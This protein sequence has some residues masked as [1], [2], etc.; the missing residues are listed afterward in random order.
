MTAILITLLLA[1]ILGISIAWSKGFLTNSRTSTFLT[2]AVHAPLGFLNALRCSNRL[3]LANVAEGQSLNGLKTY[4]S[5]AVIA[6]RYLIC[7]FGTDAAHI[8]LTAAGDLP[9][10]VI[11]DAAA[12]IG[13]PVAVALFDAASGTQKVAINSNVNYNDLLTTDA[14]GYAKTLPTADGTYWVIGRALQSGA[15]G[16]TIEFVPTFPFQVQYATA[17]ATSRL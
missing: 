14:N 10:G 3:V 12:A 7:K 2:F 11:T 6:S 9:L 4:L 1:A 15:A 8:N 17:V 13:D 16:D 5:D